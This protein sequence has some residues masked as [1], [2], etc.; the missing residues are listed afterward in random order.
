MKYIKVYLLVAQ[1]TVRDI[2]AAILQDF[3]EWI[4]P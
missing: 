4:A 3:A 2:I 1:W